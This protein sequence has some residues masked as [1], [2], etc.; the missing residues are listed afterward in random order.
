MNRQL[1]NLAMF[2]RRMASGG[3]VARLLTGRVH[4][5]REVAKSLLGNFH[6]IYLK[7]NWCHCA[8]R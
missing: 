6:E 2:S 7:M 8:R 1:N 5:Q 3:T 4:L